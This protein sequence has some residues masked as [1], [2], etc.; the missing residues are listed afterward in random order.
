MERIIP[1]FS[2]L[3]VQAPVI[4]VWLVGL[5]L[6]LVYWNKH[7][8]VS[9]LTMIGILGLLTTLIIGSSVSMW[10]PLT[11]NQRG[12][13]PAQIAIFVGITGLIISLLSAVFWALLI[14]AIFGW[15][16]QSETSR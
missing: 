6:S 16:K 13:H 8:K 5:G 1:S 12:M 4:I 11:L 10:L 2:I 14:I 9:L 3:L 15:R 7:P